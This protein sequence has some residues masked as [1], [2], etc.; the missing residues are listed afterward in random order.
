[1][2]PHKPRRDHVTGPRVE[3]VG[4]PAAACLLAACLG[5]P[6]HVGAGL[7]SVVPQPPVLPPPVKKGDMP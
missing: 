5:Y 6:A 7:A 1:V 4:D 3:Q 2:T